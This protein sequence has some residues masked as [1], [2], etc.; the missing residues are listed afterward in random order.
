MPKTDE[1]NV[2]ECQ[3]EI[4]RLRSVIRADERLY[5]GIQLLKVRAVPDVSGRTIGNVMEEMWIKAQD[6]KADELSFEFNRRTITIKQNGPGIGS[7]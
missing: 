5:S 2:L 1:E 3:K 4:R 6:L 7:A